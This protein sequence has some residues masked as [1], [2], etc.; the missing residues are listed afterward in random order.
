LSGEKY[1]EKYYNQTMALSWN[2]IKD[3]ALR[4]TKEWTGEERESAESKSFWDAFFDVF[5]ITRRRIASYETYVKKLGDE[6][7]FIDLLWKG[8]LISRT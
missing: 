6:Y 7:G 4:F 2:E 5:G 1:K 8:T 3:R